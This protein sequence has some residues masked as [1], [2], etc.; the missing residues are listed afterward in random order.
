MLACIGFDEKALRKFHDFNMEDKDLCYCY[1]NIN[2]II[3]MVYDKA[4]QELP[5]EKQLQKCYDFIKRWVDS[6]SEYCVKG[7][8]ELEN[9]CSRSESNREPTD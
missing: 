9:E 6:F 7:G 8:Y 1:S 4:F 5:E 3:S 2:S